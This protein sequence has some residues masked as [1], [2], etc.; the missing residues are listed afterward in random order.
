MT[1]ERPLRLVSQLTPKGIET[2]QF[3]SGDEAIRAQLYDEFGEA[4]VE[5]YRSVEAALERRLLQWG[6]ADEDDSDGEHTARSTK[7]LSDI[8]KRKLVDPRTWKRD[9]ALVEMATLL[10]RMLG[11]ELFRDYNLFREQVDTTLKEL[12]RKLAAAD[13]KAILR[14]VSW[15]EDDAAP[16]IA[17]VH[18]PGTAEPDPLRGLYEHQRDSSTFAVEYEPDPELRDIEQV[19]LTDDGGIEAFVRREVLPYAPDAWIDE[20]KT[21]IGYEIS[22]TRHFYKPQALR[23]LGEIRADILAIEKE[24]EGLMV[25]ILGADA[26]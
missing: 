11:G 16:V 12:G 22:F 24:A 5:N 2:L 4:L 7:S 9:A 14:A 6:N 18:K 1:V 10:R 25:A 23:S 26:Q 19:P 3:A 17:R 8:R 20:S 21:K 13:R 15:R